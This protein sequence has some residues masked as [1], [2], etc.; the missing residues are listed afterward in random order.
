MKQ[1]PDLFVTCDPGSVGTGLALFNK[2][3]TIP[4]QTW[5]FKGV[6]A[7]NWDLNRKY[8]LH[9]CNNLFGA[10]KNQTPKPILYVEEPQFMETS[11]KGITSAR[12]GS[13]MKLIATYG[14]ILAIAELNSIETRALP[15]PIWKGQLD[16]KKVHL[17][18]ERHYGHSF[19]EH[20]A[21]AVGMGLYLITGKL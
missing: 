14:G 9:S 21:D 20:V 11:I 8:I 12:Q 2:N 10:L 19:E 3:S 1:L 7:T 17:R 4:I 5:I 6:S 15:I 16:K 18:L 13:L